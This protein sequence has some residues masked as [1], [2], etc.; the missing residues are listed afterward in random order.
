MKKSQKYLY[1]K[2]YKRNIVFLFYGSSVSFKEI[3]GLVW[4]F[5]AQTFFL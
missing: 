4:G 2:S 1:L 5:K 3:L